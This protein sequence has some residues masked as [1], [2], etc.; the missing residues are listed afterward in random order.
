MR[1]QPPKRTYDLT[2]PANWTSG[3]ILASPHSGCEYPDWFL[4]ESNLD[5]R[6]LRSSEDAFVD[7]LV[8]SA[9][10]AGA[11]LLTARVPR[12]VVDLNRAADELD[13]V[14]VQGV[15][16]TVPGPRILAGLGVLPRVV[17][18]GRAIHR[19][20]LTRAEADRRIQELWHPY[21]AALAQVIAR[22]RAHFGAAIL[23]DM[24]SM[25]RESLSDL[26]RP[27][28]EV[29]LGDRHGSSAAHQI[30]TA[31][32]DAFT[33]EGFQVA[34]NTPFAGAYI[35]SHYGRPSN[36]VHAIQVEIDRSL[37]MDEQGIQPL[38]GFDAFAARI[39]A[40]IGRLARLGN[41]GNTLPIAAE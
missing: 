32:A 36:R 1:H 9:P 30:T 18:G 3:V 40:V 15:R 28:P 2:Y 4:A 16:S 25:P 31:V 39:G 20:P 23:I 12:A 10:D 22:A 11:A 14:L 34:R 26:P 24:H 21:H 29:V 37:Y 19:A 13:P 7:R 38:P 35:A 6:L 17:A 33:A 5:E 27:H 41:A 8:A